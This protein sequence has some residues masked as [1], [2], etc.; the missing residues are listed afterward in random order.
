[1]RS[2]RCSRLLCEIWCTK[3]R[4]IGERRFWVSVGDA[5][6]P[7]DS[8]VRVDTINFGPQGRRERRATVRVRAT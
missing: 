5:E 1:M 8:G 2:P 4:I 6:F 3:R 7:G